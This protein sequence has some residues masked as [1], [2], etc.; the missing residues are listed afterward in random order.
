MASQGSI[1][2]ISIGVKDSEF[3]FVLELKDRDFT[4]WII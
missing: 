1:T 3:D 4:N 2:S